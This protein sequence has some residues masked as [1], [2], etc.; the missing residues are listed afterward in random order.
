M[1]GSAGQKRVSVN[2]IK[3]FTLGIPTVEEQKSILAE[4]EQKLVQID[5]A[6]EIE[7]GNIKNLQELKA[8]IISD[9]VTGEIDVRSEII[10]EYEYIEDQSDEE[11]DEE[12]IETE[13]QE[14]WQWLLPTQRKTALNP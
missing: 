12:N 11:A 9:A 2:Y 1:T 5:K 8:R 7:R 10:P 14:D 13:E 4:I 6:I 3:N